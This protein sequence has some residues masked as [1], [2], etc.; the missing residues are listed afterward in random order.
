MTKYHDQFWLTVPAG[1]FPNG[2]R[3]IAAGGHIRNLKGNSSLTHKKQ[4]GWTGRGVK[5]TT[6]RAYLL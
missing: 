1:K 5:R 6:L 2:E 3:N 4:R